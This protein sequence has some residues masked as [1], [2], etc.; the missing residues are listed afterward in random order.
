MSFDDVLAKTYSDLLDTIKNP[1]QKESLE[2]VHAACNFLTDAKLK[3]T[4]SSVEK[5]CLDRG[6]NGPRAQSI[7]NSKDVLLKYLNQ[8]GSGQQLFSG[9]RKVARAPVIADESVRAYVQLL[10]QQLTQEKESRR[11][12]EA[13]LRKI[14]GI[15]VDAL[16]SGGKS[17]ETVHMGSP[18]EGIPP[19]LL[20]AVRAL[21]DEKR[22]EKCGLEQYKGRIWAQVTHNV[23][24]EKNE[25]A[26]LQKLIEP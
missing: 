21:F 9:K 4:P 5:Y 2:R 15:S 7:R 18:R 6:F 22:L 16:L 12:V 8:R 26:A 14:P 24:L 11:R 10:E 3:I 19:E 1:R 25:L 17:K 20:T 13:G 23:L